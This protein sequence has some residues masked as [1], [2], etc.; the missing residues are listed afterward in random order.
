MGCNHWVFQPM[1]KPD[2]TTFLHLSRCLR[3]LPLPPLLFAAFTLTGCGGGD[4]DSSTPPPTPVLNVAMQ[5]IK[6]L[7][8]SWT[9]TDQAT[10]YRLFVQTDASAAREP[11]ATLS[12]NI[13]QH[14]L[15]VF[16]PDQ[17]NARYTLQADGR[18]EVL[19]RC[20]TAEGEMVEAL[21]EARQQGAGDSPRLKVRFAPAWLSWL[22][23]VWGDYWVIDLDDAYQL[24]AVSEPGRDYLWVLSRTPTVDA[25]AYQALLGRLQAHGFDL[26]KLERSA[27][28]R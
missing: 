5:D 20:R 25:A 17:V 7:R 21:G 16:L 22:P 6:T 12:A 26:S 19:N 24:V 2:V 13:T 8:F 28:A 10:S 1:W 15:S 18:V 27:Q 4:G 9:V 14:A 11:V 23:L 3:V